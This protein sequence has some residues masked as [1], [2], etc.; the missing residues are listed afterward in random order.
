[1]IPRADYLT[2]VALS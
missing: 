1:M 2:I